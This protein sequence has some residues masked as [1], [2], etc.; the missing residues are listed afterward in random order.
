MFI[1]FFLLFS[2][3]WRYCPHKVSAYCRW[4]NLHF[5]IVLTFRRKFGGLS[6]PFLH[7]QT[8]WTMEHS[9][10]TLAARI[11]W[12]W[13]ERRTRS[14]LAALGRTF[15]TWTRAT[16][17]CC[18]SLSQE[19]TCSCD[20]WGRK[21]RPAPSPWMLLQRRCAGACTAPCT[22]EPQSRPA[23]TSPSLAASRSRRCQWR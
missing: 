6:S 3:F 10:S 18:P 7:L 19:G 12:I 5:P 9:G 21:R 13:P 1:C 16:W 11:G 20:W 17:A 4:V 14:P 22:S 15:C 2:G 23:C 8:S